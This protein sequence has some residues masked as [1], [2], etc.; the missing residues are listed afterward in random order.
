MFHVLVVDDDKNIRYVMKEVL[1]TNNKYTVFTASSADEA[2]DVL[3]R[4]H[5]DLAIVDIMMP[6]ESGL[7][8]LAKLRVESSVPVIMLTAMG[9]VEDRI[10][11]LEQGADDY[12]SKPFE[13]KE[14][15]LRIGSILKRTPK[16]KKENQAVKPQAP[17]SASC[18]IGDLTLLSSELT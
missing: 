9:D 6:K 4:E 10:A 12:V 2:F 18:V 14:L 11:G 5:I 17:T 3:V 8:F 16:E 15:L 13:P 1:E 7:D